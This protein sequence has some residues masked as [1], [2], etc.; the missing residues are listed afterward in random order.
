MEYTVGTKVFGDWEI[1]AEIGAIF[2]AEP[3]C[4]PSEIRVLCRSG[5]PLC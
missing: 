5:N 1:T 4:Y 3:D 2:A